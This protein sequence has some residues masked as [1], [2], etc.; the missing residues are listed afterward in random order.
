[1]AKTLIDRADKIAADAELANV[2]Q[3]A[4]LGSST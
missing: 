2:A 4:A 3:F 1:M